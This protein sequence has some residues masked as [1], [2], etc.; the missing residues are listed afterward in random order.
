M[1]QLR[2]VKMATTTVTEILD[3][4][5]ECYRDKKM[6]QKMSQLLWN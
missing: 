6:S 2:V 4:D 3:P 1:P 5:E